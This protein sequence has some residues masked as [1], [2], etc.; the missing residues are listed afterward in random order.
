[1]LNE[2]NF[3]EK[4]KEGDEKSY[5]ILV[6]KYGD[7]LYAYI[8]SLSNDPILSQDI[9]QNVFLKIWTKRQYIN[10][11]KSIESYLFRTAY[12]EFINQYKR[13]RAT[14]VLEQKYFRAL[15]KATENFKE[16]SYEK[17]YDMVNSEIENLPPKCKQVFILSRKEGL[18][19]T[20]ISNYLNV[21]IK[22]VEAHITKAFSV[23]RKKLGEKIEIALFMLFG[24]N[25][26]ILNKA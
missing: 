8:L 16:D 23:L 22:S 5:N 18:S 14:M 9:L 12:N 3:I 10:I 26:L 20:E 13:K 7:R 1:M 4:L 25:A 19:N 21:S 24:R 2:A 6:D 15:E 17:L 11:I